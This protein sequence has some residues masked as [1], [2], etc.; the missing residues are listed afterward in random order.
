[1]TA[2]ET[3]PELE[4]KQGASPFVAPTYAIRDVPFDAGL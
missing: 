2:P 4:A 1:M 3:V